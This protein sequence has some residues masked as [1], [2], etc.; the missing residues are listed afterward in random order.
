MRGYGEAGRTTCKPFYALHLI[1]FLFVAVVYDRGGYFSVMGKNPI[2]F[3]FALDFFFLLWYNYNEPIHLFIFSS[4][5]KG[6]AYG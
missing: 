4:L 6:D 1:A 3:C 5:N 2:F